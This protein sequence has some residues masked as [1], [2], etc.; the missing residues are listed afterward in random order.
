MSNLNERYFVLA[1]LSNNKVTH[2]HSEHDTLDAACAEGAKTTHPD[3]AVFTGDRLAEKLSGPELVACFNA[4][5]EK[6][7]RVERFS[8]RG[9]A[10]Q[11]ILRAW[12]PHKDAYDASLD[13]KCTGAQ[14]QFPDPSAG[15]TLHS[16]VIMT[17]AVKNQKQ[18]A[19][20]ATTEV[21]A[22]GGNDIWPD[23]PADN[24]EKRVKAKKT[25][26]VAAPKED[27][28]TI[29]LAAKSAYKD[30]VWHKGSLRGRAFAWLAE[31]DGKIVYADAVRD[32]AKKL[33]VAQGVVRGLIVKI[34]ELKLLEVKA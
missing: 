15:G 5:V 27:T 3:Y 14:K 23:A 2:I 26:A 6:T 21:V 4:L 33:G 31:Q 10:V 30:K 34:A 19:P 16:L 24:K 9:T 1:K 25:K 32:L 29:V 22:P 20:K 13:P 17:D 18:E 12:E 28:R 11:R 7:D 8:D